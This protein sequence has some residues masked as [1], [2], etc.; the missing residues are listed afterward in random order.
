MD[1]F[2]IKVEGI[3]RQDL[4]V[5]ER[6]IPGTKVVEQP[7]LWGSGSETVV[8]LTQNIIV[9][10]VAWVIEYQKRLPARESL[11]IE[12]RRAK[13]TESPKISLG[14]ADIV[15]TTRMLRAAVGLD[16]NNVKW[17]P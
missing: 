15:S 9:D 13:V 5:I 16:Y 14:N 1:Q 7:A 4:L 11:I 2:S 17:P 8:F 12:L 3:I 6:T 10:A